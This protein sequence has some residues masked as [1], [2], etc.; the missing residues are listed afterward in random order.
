METKTQRTGIIY[1]AHNKVS[2]KRYIGLTINSLNKR[3]IHHYCKAG[4]PNPVHFHRALLKYKIEDWIWSILEEDILQEDLNN[5]EIYWIEKYNTYETGYNGTSGGGGQQGTGR[6][7]KLY[8]DKYGWI[9]STV[10]ELAS[11]YNLDTGK[12]HKVIASIY[13]QHKGWRLTEKE[14]DKYSK[15]RNLLSPLL[16]KIRI[17]KKQVYTIQDTNRILRGTTTELREELGLSKNQFTRLVARGKNN[18]LIL[19]SKEF[20]VKHYIRNDKRI[21]KKT[22][23]IRILEIIIDETL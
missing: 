15:R 5:R 22:Y 3:R 19:L 10:P 14:K 17:T 6:I 11:Y 20:V 2:K 7:Y 8:H 23:D 12:L 21:D 18:N 4:K 13:S 9:E 1:C 16:S